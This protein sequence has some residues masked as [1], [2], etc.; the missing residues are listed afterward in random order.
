MEGGILIEL[1][2]PTTLIAPNI[3]T[4]IAWEQSSYAIL[5]I[6]ICKATPTKRIFFIIVFMTFFLYE[7][8]QGMVALD[9]LVPDRVIGGPALLFELN[10][11]MDQGMVLPKRID[12]H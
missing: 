5:A 4:I 3:D 11:V 7:A 12:Y 6:I 8:L 2:D 10:Q 9:A 1:I